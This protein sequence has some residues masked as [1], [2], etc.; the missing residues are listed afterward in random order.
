MKPSEAGAGRCLRSGLRQVIATKGW[1][2]FAHFC[3]IVASSHFYIGFI[4]VLLWVLLG[5]LLGRLVGLLLR[6]LLGVP[7]RDVF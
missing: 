2:N 5:V 3:R 4:G 7:P 6:G 1:W